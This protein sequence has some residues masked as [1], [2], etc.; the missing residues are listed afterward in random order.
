MKNLFFSV[1]IYCSVLKPDW[2]HL[3]YQ[4]FQIHVKIRS[5][6]ALIG[7]QTITKRLL[8]VTSEVFMAVTMKN[9]V[10]W[11]VAPCRFCVNRCFGGTYHFHLRGR[12]IRER[13]TS[14]NRWLQTNISHCLIVNIFSISLE[15]IPFL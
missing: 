6:T 1:I 9:V 4:F 5:R 11:D 15:L 12:E 10:F 8:S 13:G 2:S 7:D 14:V 3:V